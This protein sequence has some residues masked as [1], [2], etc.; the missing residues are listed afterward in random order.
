MRHYFEPKKVKEG[1]F[2]W[3]IATSDSVTEHLK[4]EGSMAY[5]SLMINSPHWGMGYIKRVGIWM[6][7]SISEFPPEIHNYMLVMGIHRV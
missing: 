6:P 4:I 7:L 1:E 5:G 2:G 3:S